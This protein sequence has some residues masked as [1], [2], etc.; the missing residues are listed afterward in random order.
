MPENDLRVPAH[1]SKEEANNGDGDASAE[2]KLSSNVSVLTEMLPIY[3]A[4]ETSE[5]C[6]QFNGQVIGRVQRPYLVSE[7]NGGYG[8]FVITG[9]LYP[10]YEPGDIAFIDPAK[11]YIRGNVV[12]LTRVGEDGSRYGLFRILKDYTATEWT[13]ERLYPERETKV[14]KRDVWS[15]C[16]KV[17]GKESR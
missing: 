11:P 9:D 10:A 1:I 3:S 12:L 17:V 16:Y 15:L 4:V 8:L 2:M 6:M 7:A 5:G 14:L 13:V